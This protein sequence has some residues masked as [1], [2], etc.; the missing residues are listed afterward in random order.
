MVVKAESKVM[1]LLGRCVEAR[2]EW[3]IDQARDGRPVTKIHIPTWN[4][5]R[6]AMEQKRIGE[7]GR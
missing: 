3:P 2:K 4:T 5:I 7:E 6:S 1:R